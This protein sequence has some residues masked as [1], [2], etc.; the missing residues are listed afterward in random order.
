[1]GGWLGGGGS[2]FTRSPAWARGFPCT[3]LVTAH[4]PALTTGFHIVRVRQLLSQ[5][6]S[7][8][9]RV[10]PGTL[11]YP[12]AS[13]LSPGA[14]SRALCRS[15]SWCSCAVTPAP[16]PTSLPW[17]VSWGGDPAPSHPP[18][19]RPPLPPHPDPPYLWCR[20]TAYS[21]GVVS[22][23]V[24]G[25]AASSVWARVTDLPYSVVDNSSAIP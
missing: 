23:W 8:F 7:V 19:A 13:L 9:T 14:R 5:G 25:E 20:Y 3:V 2:S 17:S 4:L 11:H 12:L 22:G 24:V 1:M 21:T 15:L 10:P 18:S 6:L 16:L